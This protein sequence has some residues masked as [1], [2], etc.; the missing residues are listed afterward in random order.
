MCWHCNIA[1]SHLVLTVDTLNPRMKTQ[2]LHL[3]NTTENICYRACSPS[4]SVPA[5]HNAQRLFCL[6]SGTRVGKEMGEGPLTGIGHWLTGRG[7]RRIELGCWRT[8][9]GEVW[10][11]RMFFFVEWLKL[12][13]ELEVGDVGLSVRLKHTN[14]FRF[15]RELVDEGYI[16]G[17]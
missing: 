16:L 9:E 3:T 12:D 8:G 5:E 17:F 6:S 14:T 7:L 10:G 2:S 15:K 4:S 13:V 1:I 11:F